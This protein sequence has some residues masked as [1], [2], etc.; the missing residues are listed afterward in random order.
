LQSRGILYFGRD[1]V[2]GFFIR[3]IER[4]SL[5]EVVVEVPI[6]GRVSALGDIGDLP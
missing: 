5:A 4:A 3:L 1:P 2:S 6:A